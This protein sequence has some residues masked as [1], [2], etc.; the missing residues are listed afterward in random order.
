MRRF[1]MHGLPGQ[2]GEMGGF[3]QPQIRIA[4]SRSGSSLLSRLLSNLLFGDF[5]HRQGD[6]D[7]PVLKFTMTWQRTSV[8][9]LFRTGISL[10]RLTP[11]ATMKLMGIQRARAVRFPAGRKRSAGVCAMTHRHGRN[12]KVHPDARLFKGA[13][14]WADDDQIVQSVVEC[15][16]RAGAATALSSAR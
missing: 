7:G 14:D 10:S 1:Q 4:R 6:D 15:A 3:I 5:L 12:I 16:G 9:I 8:G 2:R 11:A 13:A